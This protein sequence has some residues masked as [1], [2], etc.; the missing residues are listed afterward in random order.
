MFS[1]GIRWS[2]LIVK[3]YLCIDFMLLTAV[4]F[5]LPK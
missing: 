2:G 3:L 4:G 1:H 5:V